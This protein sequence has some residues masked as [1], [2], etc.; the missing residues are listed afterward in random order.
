MKAEISRNA[1]SVE[2]RD[3][4]ARA[5]QLLHGAGVLHGSLNVREQLCGKP[6]CR[7]TRGERHRTLVLTVRSEGKSEQIYIPR[8]LEATVR[9]W[10]DQ[11]H[12][13]RD[14]LAKL[15]RLHTERIRQLKTRGA[16]SSKGS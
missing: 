4:R 13:L 2:E 16:R 12:Q 10:V 3:C 14:L 5:A 1:M 9:R 11:D 6:N 8:H 7:C 15:A